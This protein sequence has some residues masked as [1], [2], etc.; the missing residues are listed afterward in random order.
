MIIPP[1][2][3][4]TV[5]PEPIE[6]PC[7]T[8]PDC[9]YEDEQI[10]RNLKWDQWEYVCYANHPDNPTGELHIKGYEYKYYRGYI[11]NINNVLAHPPPEVEEA[12]GNIIRIISRPPPIS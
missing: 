9:E 8:P 7:A 3:S 12:Q 10:A 6:I 4:P 5:P 1:G 2:P 11:A